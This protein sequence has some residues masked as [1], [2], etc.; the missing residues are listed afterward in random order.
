MSSISDYVKCKQCGFESA[1]YDLNC[2][3]SEWDV[4]CGKCGYYA[5][6]E[7]HE[8]SDGK[9]TW[10]Y[11]EEQ[12]FGVLFYHGVNDLP[13]CHH[14]L[15]SKESVED[16][17]KWL[18]EQ[19]ASGEVETDCSYLSRW[20]PETMTVEF[21]IGTFYGFSDYEPPAPAKPTKPTIPI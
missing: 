7:R 18:R 12:G 16:A 1:Y 20:N 3:S 14:P 13:Y 5:A 8:D 9:I 4:S 21:V 17:E 11:P 19:V 15:H 2:R 6:A 10:T